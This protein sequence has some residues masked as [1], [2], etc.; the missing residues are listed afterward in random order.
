MTAS[1][2][3]D[4]LLLEDDRISMY[5]LRTGHLSMDEWKAIDTQAGK[6]YN[7]NINIAD[8]HNIRYINN[9]KSEARRMK[10]QSKL[11]ILFI[12]YLGLIRTNMKF[13]TRDLEIGYIT[14]ELKNLAKE[15]PFQNG[16]EKV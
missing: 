13:G 6:L 1:Q 9:I 3:A 4:R 5:N 15:L 8:S 16:N 10:R 2:L 11:D 12:D 7:L 14:G